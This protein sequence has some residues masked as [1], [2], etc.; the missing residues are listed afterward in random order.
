[1]KKFIL[2]A[3][4][5][6]GVS[7]TVALLTPQEK[8][9]IALD[10]VDANDRA[11]KIIAACEEANKVFLSAT[12]ETSEKLQARFKEL[13]EEADKIVEGKSEEEKRKVYAEKTN[14]YR[15]EADEINAAST[16][17]PDE[18]VEVVLSD[19]KMEGLKSLIRMTVKS[20][21][22]SAMF[23]EAATAID[24]AQEVA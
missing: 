13:K 16:A 15:K 14:Q 19:E 17:K 12:K 11:L 5:L 2:K 21:N 8:A 4:L 22:D 24:N 7:H 18:L 1:M 20:W 9:A 3:D 6:A 10:P 23:V